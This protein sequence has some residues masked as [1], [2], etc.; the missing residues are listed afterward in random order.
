[1]DGRGKTVCGVCFRDAEI[2]ACL[3]PERPKPAPRECDVCGEMKAD[4]RA[5][6]FPPV[7]DTVVCEDC[8]R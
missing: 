8:C 5:V 2:C 4:T 7:G 1:M 3:R 6:Y